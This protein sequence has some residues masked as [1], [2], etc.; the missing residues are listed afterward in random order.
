MDKQLT[1]QIITEYL[2][3]IYGF[4]VKKAYSYDDA[5]DLCAEIVQ[6]VYLSLLRAE[7]VI[8]IEGYVWRISEHTYA[9]YVSSK[10]K[11]EGISLD[12]IS[13]PIYNDHSSLEAADATAK[14]RRGIAY[15][16]ETRREIIY[17]FYY[18]DRSM[19][20]ISKALGIPIGTV[21]WHLNKARNELKECFSMERRIGKL[22]ISPVT[23]VNFGHSGNPGNNSAPEIYLD[24]KLTLNMVYACYHSPKTTA[25]IAEELGVTPVFIEDKMDILYADGT[26]R[27]LTE[28][29]KVTSDL[30]MFSD[31]LP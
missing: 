25:Q 6:E 15:L 18:R 29:E 1:D 7:N 22:G 19:S 31:I 30:I 21:K 5:E 14:L 2:P 10:K 4:A 17:Q 28:N 23:A 20:N 12:A 16:T 24:D 9:K 3:K 8:N 27:S 11:H 13:I 26:F